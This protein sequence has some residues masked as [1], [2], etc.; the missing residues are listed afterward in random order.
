[1]QAACP[2]RKPLPKNTPT[3]TCASPAAKP[4][5]T[6]C[7]D[8]CT[9][10]SN[11]PHRRTKTWWRTLTKPS[12]SAAL[13]ASAPVR[14]MRLWAHPN[15]CTPCWRTNAPAAASVCRPAP[16][17]ALI[18]CPARTPTCPPRMIWRTTKAASVLPPPHT[19]KP[20]MTTGRHGRRAKPPNANAST[21]NAPRKSKSTRR[22]TMYRKLTCR[23]L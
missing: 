4:C 16:S 12:A 2:M 9:A 3:S 11:M 5:C 13:P 15:S 21:L 20:A 19:P 22:K 6:T 7:P 18:Y 10:R 1:M 8:C 14:S 17:I 23:L